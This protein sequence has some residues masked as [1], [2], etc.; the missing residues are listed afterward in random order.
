[1]EETSEEKLDS[2]WIERFKISREIGKA[3]ELFAQLELNDYDLW[4]NYPLDRE[5]I[6]LGL[7]AKLY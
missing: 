4:K 1:Y 5:K 7:K 6:S 3:I 2:G